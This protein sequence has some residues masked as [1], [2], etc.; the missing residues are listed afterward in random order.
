MEYP[1]F[2]PYH[3]INFIQK[4]SFPLKHRQMLKFVLYLPHEHY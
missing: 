2:F 3:L 1:L 4:N